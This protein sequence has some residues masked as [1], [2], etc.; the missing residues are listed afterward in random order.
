M[1][2][3]HVFPCLPRRVSPPSCSRHGPR[4][5]HGRDSGFRVPT[6]TKSHPPHCRKAISDETGLFPNPVCRV[7]RL[8]GL[9]LAGKGRCFGFD[10]APSCD[11]VARWQKMSP[12]C[13]RAGFAICG[14][15]RDD[16]AH[17]ILVFLTLLL[18]AVHGFRRI[19][20]C[21]TSF[22]PDALYFK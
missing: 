1:P 21:S 9:S 18:Q 15:T 7:T 16:V 20:V 13:S 14:S 5:A 6:D 11:R 19:Y 4:R 8:P 3:P 2:A 10:L 12:R 22:T 17:S